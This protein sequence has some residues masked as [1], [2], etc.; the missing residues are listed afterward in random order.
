MD[1]CSFQPLDSRRRAS[2]AAAMPGV[3][4]EAPT[5]KEGQPCNLAAVLCSAEARLRSQNP[6]A[7][8]RD[9]LSSRATR[10]LEVSRS[11][12]R[13]LTEDA[14]QVEQGRKHLSALDAPSPTQ[15]LNPA[16]R[17]VHAARDASQPCHGPAGPS[18]PSI[19]AVS[20][21]ADQQKGT[22]RASPQRS[23]DQEQT[24]RQEAPHGAALFASPRG[25][26]PRDAR[27]LHGGA[28][29]V[30]GRHAGDS[31]GACVRDA[32]SQPSCGRC[33]ARNGH[34]CAAPSTPHT[35]LAT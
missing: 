22:H 12:P 26:V 6:T 31:D 15:A 30:A 20:A 14:R 11:Q 28:H 33:S 7:V 34:R 17:R 5:R 9:P 23:K 8:R 32:R 21:I 13:S 2:R 27:C 29:P 1:H 4:E 35:R 18:A 3:L 19:A 24:P 16:L 25:P 10:P